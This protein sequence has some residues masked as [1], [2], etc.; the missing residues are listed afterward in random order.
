MNIKRKRIYDE[1]S[2]DD[3]ARFL[4]DRLW[5]RGVSK[6]RA[7][8]DGWFK[9]VTPS[10]DLRKWFDHDPA[11]WDEFKTAYRQELSKRANALDG[12]IEEMDGYDD[13]TLLYAAKDTQHTHAIILQNVV[14]ERMENN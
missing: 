2:E 13:I 6:E 10:P 8:L 11:K 4:V 5:P 12:L 14:E 3:G 7:D 1:S 9:N